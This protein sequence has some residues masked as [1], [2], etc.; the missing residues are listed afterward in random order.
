MKMRDNRQ[1]P[2]FLTTILGSMGKWTFPG[3][4]KDEYRIYPEHFLVPELRE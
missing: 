1:R 3:L 4:G 2:W